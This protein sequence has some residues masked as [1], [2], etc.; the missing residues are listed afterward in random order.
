MEDKATECGF[1]KDGLRVLAVTDIVGSQ[2][3]VT[4]DKNPHDIHI[5]SKPLENH[6]ACVDLGREVQHH[7]TSFYEEWGSPLS[8]FQFVSLFA[9]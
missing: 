4:D 7:G 1:T 9:K 3:V 8:L 2:V 6:E 5:L